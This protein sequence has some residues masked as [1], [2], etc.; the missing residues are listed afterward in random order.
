MKKILL[1]SFF[2]LL[3]FGLQAQTSDNPWYVGAGVNGISLQN[4]I[5]RLNNPNVTTSK[6]G[7]QAFNFGVPSLS[8]FRAI[9]GGLSIGGNLS[10]NNIKEETGNGEI[11]Y[12]NLDA[13]LKYGFNRNGSVSPYIKGGWG[14]SSFDASGGDTE[15][16]NLYNPSSSIGADTYIGGA[17]LSFRQGIVGVL[18]LKVLSVSP[19]MT[20]WQT[21][22]NTL[23]GWL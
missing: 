10:L 20:Q 5:S 23:Q 14:L 2:V 17:G 21:S 3:A 8:V 12:Y 13:L 18:L 15:F 1:S 16:S 19:K 11:K 6:D 22:Y 9:V 7:L 4:D